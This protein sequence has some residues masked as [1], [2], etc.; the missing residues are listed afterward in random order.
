MLFKIRIEKLSVE[1]EDG[2]I[3]SIGPDELTRIYEHIADPEAA[4][5][6]LGPIIGQHAISQPIERQAPMC[7]VPSPGDPPPKFGESER[8]YLDRLTR[9]HAE[10]R[11]KR[12][13]KEKPGDPLSVDPRL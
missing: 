12:A 9:L 13:A 6:A 5:E 3:I 10:R 1:W 8:A 7:W 4:C 2:T 11:R